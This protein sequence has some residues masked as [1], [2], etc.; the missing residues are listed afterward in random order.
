MVGM[1]VYTETGRM[2]WREGVKS[3][4]TWDVAV[5]HLVLVGVLPLGGLR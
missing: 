5:A 1:I 4:V 2:E 3:L